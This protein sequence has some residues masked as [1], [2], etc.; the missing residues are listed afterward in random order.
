MTKKPVVRVDRV[1]RK[2]PG[3]ERDEVTG[4][5]RKLHNN[6]L[7]EYHSSPK[8]IQIIKSGKIKWTRCVT[9]RKGESFLTE[10]WWGILGKEPV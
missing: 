4:E 9:T 7:H 1:L 8:I 3:P 5:W 2:T 10:F 6:E